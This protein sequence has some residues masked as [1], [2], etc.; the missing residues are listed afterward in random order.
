MMN[1]NHLRQRHQFLEECTRQSKVVRFLVGILI[2]SCASAVHSESIT[3][4]DFQS[5]ADILAGEGPRLY[6]TKDGVFEAIVVERDAKSLKS[7]GDGF[8]ADGVNLVFR[9]NLGNDIP[10]T[11]AWMKKGVN[12]FGADTD[13]DGITD[14]LVGSSRG[15]SG[16]WMAAADN[17][18][19]LQAC[20]E[21]AALAG[22]V[23]SIAAA[24]LCVECL[25]ADRTFSAEARKCVRDGARGGVRLSG[26]GVSA[27]LEEFAEPNCGLSKPGE[28]LASEGWENDEDRIRDQEAT[29]ERARELKKLVIIFLDNAA[30]AA[31]DGNDEAANAA[32]D[33]SDSY[34]SAFPFYEKAANAA[35]RGDLDGFQDALN[36]AFEYEGKADSA[37]ERYENAGG[38]GPVNPDDPLGG[39]AGLTDP[40]CGGGRDTYYWQRCSV[41]DNP[42][43][44]LRQM[45]DSTYWITDGRCWNELGPDGQPR[46]VCAR[47]G[48]GD[49]GEGGGDDPG[50]PGGTGSGISDGRSL[51]TGGGGPGRA[52]DNTPLGALLISLCAQGGCP[53]P[54]PVDLYDSE[55]ASSEK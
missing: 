8:Y 32:F 9:G 41:G 45:T 28:G 42:L 35:R 2:F 37:V 30:D 47:E 34:D 13:R 18:E 54:L 48:S 51:P 6:E 15:E 52:V 39:M 14:V 31:A 46:L 36:N 20:F 27:P 4:A 24:A 10:F 17:F 29:E 26:A 11:V 50:N 33:A 12:V 43:A 19:Y 23:D 3:L 21:E 5:M 22:A 7:L 49:G 55:A 44:C 25:G 40:R 53:D 1:C 16:L 38:Q